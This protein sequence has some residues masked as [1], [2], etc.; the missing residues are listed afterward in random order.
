MASVNGKRLWVSDIGDAITVEA[1]LITRVD[2]LTAPPRETHEL[3]AA[4]Q[5]PRRD[6]PGVRPFHDPRTNLSCQRTRHHFH[7]KVDRRCSPRH[8]PA[9]AAVAQS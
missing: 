1:L 3:A 4:P 6:P 7:L 8:G 9:A 5:G 2:D